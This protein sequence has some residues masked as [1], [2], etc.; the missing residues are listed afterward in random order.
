LRPVLRSRLAG[1]LPRAVVVQ[2]PLGHSITPVFLRVRDPGCFTFRPPG[3]A[4][5]LFD[6]CP[7]GSALQQ[8]S[9]PVGGFT[10]HAGVHALVDG[11]RDGGAGVPEA[12]GDDL[13]RHAV[14]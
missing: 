12:L 13:H 8:G 9:E 3:L 11:E 6:T 7:L 1:S 4:W 10:A 2:V 14:G 5:Y